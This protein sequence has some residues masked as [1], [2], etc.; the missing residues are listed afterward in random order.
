MKRKGYKPI[1]FKSLQCFEAMARTGG[2]TRAGIELGISDAA[3][4]QRI[5]SLEKFLGVK[6]YE[7]RGG[8]VT[9]TDAGVHTWNFS[10]RLFEEIEEFADT[11][12]D[13][14]LQSMITLC[15]FSPALRYHLAGITKKFTELYPFAKLKLIDRRAAETI[16]LVKKNVADIGIIYER[17]FPPEI[18]FYPWRTFRAQILVPHG[19]PLAR[20]G[21][22]MLADILKKETLERYPQIIT[23]F[24]PEDQGIIIAG[25]ERLGL[26]FNVGLEVGGVD[27]VKYYVEQGLGLAVVSDIC[28]TPQD[29]KNLHLIEV[30]KEFGGEIVY[31]VILRHKKYLS[32]ALRGLLKLFKLGELPL[33]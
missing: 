1:D 25:L 4:S 20:K 10:N 33:G 23:E 7:S 13:E 30:P 19:H 9:L 31:G 5:R 2:L 29:K 16:D 3:V 26:P 18:S 28:L 8:K 17:S 22:P 12:T 24:D 27:T 11:I 15:V 6:L 14:K 21:P 32:S